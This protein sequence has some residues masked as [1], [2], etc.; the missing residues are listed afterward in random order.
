[1]F[2]HV[3]TRSPRPVTQLAGLQLNLLNNL[4]II[5]KQGFQVSKIKLMKVS[6]EKVTGTILEFVTAE[7]GGNSE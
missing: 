1:M 3:C 5:I 2:G 4:S 7:T 6:V